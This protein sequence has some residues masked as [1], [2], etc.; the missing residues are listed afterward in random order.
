[1]NKKIHSTFYKQRANFLKYSYIKAI[2]KDQQPNRK[3]RKG[4]TNG[5]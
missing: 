5:Q 4:L 3:L 2:G 1:M